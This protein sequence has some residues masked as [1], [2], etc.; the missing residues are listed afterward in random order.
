VADLTAVEPVLQQMM[1]CTAFER[2]AP[3]DVTGDRLMTLGGDPGGGEFAAQVENR[4]GFGV[5]AEDVSDR[6]GLRLDDL[7]LAVADLVAEWRPAT[8]PHALR[9]RGG[10]LVADPFAGDLALE[11]GE[12]QPSPRAPDRDGSE[13]FPRLA[14]HEPQGTSALLSEEVLPNMRA[15]CRDRFC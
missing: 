2:A 13:V 1:E 8:H 11:L 4:A 9:L 5:A 14:P 7:E 3:G 6:L 10:D 15:A 12:G